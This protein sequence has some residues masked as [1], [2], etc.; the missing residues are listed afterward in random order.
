MREF[1]AV[2][3]STCS[4]MRWRTCSTAPQA[5][6]VKERRLSRSK[7]QLLNVMANTSPM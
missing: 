1:L 3:Y 2:R 7:N 6:L 4:R 5:I